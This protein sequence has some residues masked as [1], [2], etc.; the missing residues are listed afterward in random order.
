MHVNRKYYCV[1]IK[2]H[3]LSVT[4][5][6]LIS[7]NS[8]YRSEAMCLDDICD[9][10]GKEV[11]MYCSSANWLSSDNAVLVDYKQLLHYF[12]TLEHYQPLTPP[13]GR[14]TAMLL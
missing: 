6:W 1:E 14:G 2:I 7:H 5:M 3:N 4:L 8:C 10:L 13:T 9:L 12:L 11:N